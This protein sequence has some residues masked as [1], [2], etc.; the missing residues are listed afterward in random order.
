MRLRW[1]TGPFLLLLASVVVTGC[2]RYRYVVVEPPDIA[3]VVPDKDDLVYETESAEYRLRAVS[4]RLVVRV[5]N[6][7]SLPLV[8]VGE[9]SSLVDPQGQSRPV[10]GQTIEPGSFAKWILPPPLPTI[11][12][13]GPNFYFGVGYRYGHAGP[14]RA[15]ADGVWPVD[16]EAIAPRYLRVYDESNP[17]LW[18]WPGEGTVRLRLAFERDGRRTEYRLVIARQ[19]R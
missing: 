5:F 19:K 4:D 1:L 3:G 15:D 14:R 13:T 12:R 11:E 16:G 17:Y 6:R 9:A 2:T 10:L 18:T 8:L 7:S